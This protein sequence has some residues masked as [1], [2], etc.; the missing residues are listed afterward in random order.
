R[1]FVNDVGENTWEEI[2][3][4]QPGANHG[5]SVR[6][7]HCAEGSA[8]NCGAPPAGMTNPIYDYQH[9]APNN[10]TAITGGAFVPNGVWPAYGGTYLFGDY[11]CGRIFTLM[12]NG[13]GGYTSGTFATG[14]G[15][16][17]SMAFG[18]YGATQ[19]LYYTSF[20]SGGQLHRIS[21]NGGAN[22]APNAV[23]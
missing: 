17:I 6:E 21:L 5:W 7:G 18:P 23:A 19:A 3:D 2:D 4:A 14:I 10:C 16:I 8:S 15:A 1:L 22:Q 12:P 13:A 20:S 11:G 9:G